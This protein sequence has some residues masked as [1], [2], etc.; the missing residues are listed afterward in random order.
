MHIAVPGLV[1]MIRLTLILLAGIGVTLSIAGTDPGDLDPAPPG[2]AQAQAGAAEAEPALRR[3][4]ALDDEAGAIARALAAEAR[5]DRSGAMAE[6]VLWNA[7]AED[8]RTPA[9]ASRTEGEAEDGTE[10]EDGR[11]DLLRVNADRVNLRAGPSTANRVLDQVVRDQRVEV[12][13]T[14]PSGWA[15]IHVAE[16]GLTAWIFDR[17][18]SPAG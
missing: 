6:A 11:A 15:R 13:E 16:T 3:Q 7:V 14:L 4:L 12:L 1:Q 2:A 10:S 8:S 18:L 17:F 9:P 5:S